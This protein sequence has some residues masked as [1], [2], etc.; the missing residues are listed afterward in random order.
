MNALISKTHLAKALDWNQNNIILPLIMSISGINKVNALYQKIQ[1]S[2]G[3]HCIDKIFSELNITC[4]FN[5]TTLHHIPKIGGCILISNHPYGGIDGLAL[6][7]TL[8]NHRPDIKVMANYILKGIKPIS[9]FFIP[10]NPFSS[11]IS[12]KSSVSGLKS[13]MAHVKNG[14]CLVI[15]PSGEVSAKYSLNQPVQDKSWSIS[16]VRFILKCKVPV[17]PIFF[18]GQNSKLFQA[19]GKIDPRLRTMRLPAEL[20]NKAGKV[21]SFQMGKPILPHHFEFHT[22]EIASRFLR[23]IVYA[24][25]QNI[26][27]TKSLKNNLKD[28]SGNKIPDPIDAQLIEAEIKTV[29]NCKI[30]EKSEYAV[31]AVKAYQIPH[32][33][34][35]L[36]RLREITFRDAGEGSNRSVD[37]DHYDEYYTHLILW[38]NAK[39]KIAGAYRMARG[40]KIIQLF[41]IRGLYTAS[42]FKIKREYY[43]KLNQSME[44]GRSFIV[45]EFQK[46][47]L[48]LHML[49][50]GIF[51]ILHQWS[52]VRYII[53]PVS[54]SQNYS[55]HSREIMMKHLLKFYSP[56][57]A[58]RYILP[59]NPI[60]FKKSSVDLESILSI[61]GSSIQKLNRIIS[62]IDPLGL[63]L[64]VLYKKYL[65]QHA[66][67]YAFNLDYAFNNCI[68][69]FMELDISTMH[70]NERALKD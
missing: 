44:L 10:V 50:Q 54:M 32:I 56:V 24:L 58:E 68:D 61:T 34:L 25:N 20:V 48:P 16:A 8:Y 26:E 64:P 59:R 47:H 14:G 31:Y 9:N 45:P 36:G 49:W 19:L 65:A 30:Y 53:G 13:A 67:I 17:I 40:S 3:I 39:C 1:Y 28:I 6:I 57:D 29:Q 41:G 22:P 60:K 38:H 35:E 62:I 52:E 37:L 15:F 12:D 27:S 63:S 51:R 66:K 46:Q 70:E 7:H 21:I 11:Q 5:A 18:N 69:A 33:I 4:R 2:E 43:S 42:L 23:S 55:W